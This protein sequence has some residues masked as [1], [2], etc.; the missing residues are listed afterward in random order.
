MM[1]EVRVRHYLE[2]FK[3]LDQLLLEKAYDIYFWV[4]GTKHAIIEG[5][6]TF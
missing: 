1:Y 2:Y 4:Y 6:L 3:A 5:L